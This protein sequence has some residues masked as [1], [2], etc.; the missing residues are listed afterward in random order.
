MCVVVR[1]LLKALFGLNPVA[2][3]LSVWLAL[4]SFLRPLGS[5]R[6]GALGAFAELIIVVIFNYYGIIKAP[7]AAIIFDELCA[8]VV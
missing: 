2:T 8:M 4:E 3:F 7:L 1:F 5:K 6:E